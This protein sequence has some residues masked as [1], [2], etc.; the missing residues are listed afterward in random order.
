MDEAIRNGFCK[1]Q[2]AHVLRVF[3]GRFSF[4]WKYSG[5]EYRVD[6]K[7]NGEK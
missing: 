2:V 6:S 5:G 7:R 1:R 4:Y 3:S